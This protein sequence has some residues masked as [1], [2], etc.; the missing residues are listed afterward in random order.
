MTA[1]AR[2]PGAPRRSSGDPIDDVNVALRRADREQLRR[3]HEARPELSPG[4]LR[5]LVIALGSE[6]V[7]RGGRIEPARAVLP[8]PTPAERAGRSAGR[9]NADRGDE[10]REEWEARLAA[11]VAG[12]GGTN[13]AAEALDW[14]ADRDRLGLA[15]SDRDAYLESWREGAY[16]AAAR[17]S[18]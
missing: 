5:S 13:T 6:A 17:S 18:S 14:E 16:D 2:R 10:T 12:H 4:D 3:A 9:A 1:P 8:A 11:L 15:E 7:V